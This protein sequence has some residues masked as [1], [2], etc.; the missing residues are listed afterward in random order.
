MESLHKYFAFISYNAHDL[1]WGKRLQRKLE[2]Y[3]MPATLCSERG[4]ERTPIKPVFFAPTDIQ[5]GGLSQELQDRLRASRNLIV[6]CSPQSAQS[7]WVGR[8]IAFF[9]E[10]GRTQ[11][12]HFF[13]VEGEPHSGNPDTECFNPVV[14]TLGLPEILGAN[15]HERIYRLPWLNRERAYVQMV[16]KLLDVEFDAIWQRHRRQLV[17]KTVTWIIGSLAV[18]AAFA[19]VWVANRPVDVTLRVNEATIHNPALPEMRDAAVTLFLDNKTETDTLRTMNEAVT[20]R[21]IPHKYLYRPVRVNVQCRDFLTTDT[22]LALAKAM[23]VDLARD[24]SVYGD[25]RFRL[26]DPTTE[27]YLPGVPVNIDG[28]TVVSDA[29]GTV[30]LALPLAAQRRTYPV[31]ADIPLHED[32]LYLPCGETYHIFAQQ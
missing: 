30:T 19:G 16:S 20:F 17:R 2:H 11:N 4:W 6:I 9:H 24:P 21:N 15:I 5:P 27:R 14:E 12:I 28:H 8:E 1:K 18:L 22:T 3:R 10:L 29:N 7:K 31:S 32:S 26:Y 25:I 13:I 23:T